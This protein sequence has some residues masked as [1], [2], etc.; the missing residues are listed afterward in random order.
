MASMTPA[1][2]AMR[3]VDHLPG[4]PFPQA[5]RATAARLTAAAGYTTMP[6]NAVKREADHEHA[7]HVPRDSAK[8]PPRDGP[9]AGGALGGGVVG[10]GFMRARRVMAS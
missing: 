1:Q 5:A 8:G 7:R 3:A 2:N 4:V 9:R 10:E 6:I